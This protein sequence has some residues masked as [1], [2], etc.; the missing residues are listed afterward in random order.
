MHAISLHL[1]LHA[2]AAI[3]MWWELNFNMWKPNRTLVVTSILMCQRVLAHACCPSFQQLTYT[4]YTHVAC[5]YGLQKWL[6]IYMCVISSRRS[7]IGTPCVSIVPYF[8]CHILNLKWCGFHL[9]AGL[10]R[11]VR[12]RADLCCIDGFDLLYLLHYL[13]N[14]C[15]ST[16]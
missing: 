9:H 7:V 4:E 8:C 14:W 3:L 1:V 6:H 11:G 10:A 5:I 12:A 2:F 13:V 16:L 15:C